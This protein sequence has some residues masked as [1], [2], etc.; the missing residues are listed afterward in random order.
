[1]CLLILPA[2][3]LDLSWER[4]FDSPNYGRINPWERLMKPRPKVLPQII[5][6]GHADG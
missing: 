5:H 3:Q 6:V 2:N 4:I 1:M